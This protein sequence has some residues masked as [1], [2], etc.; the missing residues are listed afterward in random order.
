[1]A[2]LG[3]YKYMDKEPQASIN[4]LIA[5]E[6]ELT[7]QGVVLDFVKTRVDNIDKKFDMLVE[8]MDGKFSLKEESQALKAIT[9]DHEQ[10]LRSL[11]RNVWKAIGALAVLELL[12]P[13]LL[14][15]FKL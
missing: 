4:K 3:K 1:M 5:D 6:K 12:I 10:R 2:Q 11:E 13:I 14:H 7:R 9:M 8:K 15:Y